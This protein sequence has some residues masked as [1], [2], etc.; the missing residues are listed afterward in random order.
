MGNRTNLTV[1]KRRDLIR[2][3]IQD[4]GLLRP[5][6][7]RRYIMSKTGKKV[8]HRT[9]KND[10]KHINGSDTR[11]FDD[12]SR[13]GIVHLSVHYIQTMIKE[14]SQARK[15]ITALPDD[16]AKE[17][18]D[19]LT[20]QC[21]LDKRLEALFVLLSE[22]PLTV[23]IDKIVKIQA[24][25][26]DVDPYEMNISLTKRLDDIVPGSLPTNQ[27]HSFTKYDTS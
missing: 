4:A 15:K 14:I 9:I 21:Q 2:E 5:A 16:D 20:L 26:Q 7:I 8:D 12:Y 13:G 24:K 10:L 27:T 18:K 1:S 6:E 17:L 11:A 3:I 22:Y 25:D 19:K 23:T